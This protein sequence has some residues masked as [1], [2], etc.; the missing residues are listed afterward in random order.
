MATVEQAASLIVRF[1]GESKAARTNTISSG[2][3]NIPG[4]ARR[5]VNYCAAKGLLLAEEYTAG[6]ALSAELWCTMLLRAVGFTAEDISG[7]SAVSAALRTVVRLT[8]NSFSSS[9]SGGSRSPT[10]SLRGRTCHEAAS[11]YSFS[12]RFC[13]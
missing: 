13:S 12:S 8:E 5:D 11:L 6:A 9:G 4:W 3:E 1:L 2:W 10:A 7:G